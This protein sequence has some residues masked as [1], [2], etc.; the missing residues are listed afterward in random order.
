MY[1]P[2]SG[3]P[4]DVEVTVRGEMPVAHAV[5]AKKVLTH[6][7]NLPVGPAPAK[8]PIIYWVLGLHA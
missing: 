4:Q 1:G 7:V 2:L 3:E 6:K 5:P 8:T